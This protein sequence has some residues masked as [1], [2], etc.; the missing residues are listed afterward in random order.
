ML[1]I[2]RLISSALAVALACAGASAAEHTA[3]SPYITDDVSSVVYV[4]LGK[5]NLP[6][7]RAEME[8]LQL[9]PEAHLESSKQE[10]AAIQSAFDEL[11]KLGAKR[12]Y[13]LVRVTDFFNGGPVVVIEVAD[14]G[15]SQAVA[16]WLKSMAA[17]AQALGDVA[18]YLPKEFEAQGT[19]VVGAASRE[20]LKATQSGRKESPRPEPLE[21]LAALGNDDAGWVM[22]GDA[23][24][25]RVIREM[26]PQLPA[27]FMEIDGRLLADGLKWGGLT[28]KLPPDPTI[29]LSFETTGEDTSAILKIAAGKALMIVKGLLLV[30][31]T[32]NAPVHK[33]RAKAALPILPLLEPAV[34]GNRLTITFGDDQ[35]EKEFLSSYLPLLVEGVQSKAHRAHRMNQFKRIGLAM[36]NYASTVG[37]NRFPAAASYSDDG[38]PLL[39]WRVRMLAHTGNGED[40]ELYHKFHLDEPWDSEHNRTLIEQMPEIYTDP[41]L[42]IRSQ[43]KPGETTYVAPV[44]KGLVFE[45]REGSPL[46]SITDGTSNTIIALEVVPERAVVWTKPED[47]EVDLDA[48]LDG[49][50]RNDRTIFAAL[51]ADG[52]ARTIASN[53]DAKTFK[54]WLT[55]AGK[56]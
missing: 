40:A 11:T 52:S 55:R 34:D 46:Q 24:S 27:P 18:A 3:V 38:R 25:R 29:T 47:W 54:G 19:M 51:F 20:R 16:D 14:K 31:M 37:S 32:S 35:Q 21:A 42:R 6:A 44:G 12:A 48:P 13:V 56:D 49:V 8:K 10:S 4:D 23:D 36:H 45:G 1:R 2:C 5:F 30:D 39:S 7:I 9:I 15:Q 41:D 28:L 22:L 53:I 33:Q 50:K 26:F 17:K 43:L